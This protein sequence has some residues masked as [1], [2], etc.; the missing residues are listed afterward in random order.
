MPW[1]GGYTDEQNHIFKEFPV[2]QQHPFSRMC[3]PGCSVEAGL[4]SV[5]E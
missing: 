4:E 1:D 2:F 3:V 5:V